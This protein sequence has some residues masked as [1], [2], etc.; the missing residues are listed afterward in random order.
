VFCKGT[1]APEEILGYIYI[2]VRESMKILFLLLSFSFLV[3]ALQGNGG[4]VYDPTTLTFVE[5]AKKIDELPPSGPRQHT[6]LWDT[7][8][9]VHL[10]YSPNGRYSNLAAMLVD[11]GFTIVMNGQ[12]VHNIDLSPYDIIVINI[13][14]S[15]N[16]AYTGAE[17][18]ALLSWYDNGHQQVIHTS[19]ANWCD[20]SYMHLADDSVFSCN[21]FKHLS[22]P[23]G[24]AIMSENTACPNANVAPV[25]Q[26][27]NMN[28]G[29][30]YLSPSDLYFSNFAA[31]PIYNSVS[32]VYYRAA[33]ELSAS[34]PA[35]EI[36]WTSTN[37]GTVAEMN[38]AIAIECAEF[39]ASRLPDAIRLRW[40]TTCEIGN[41]AWRIEAKEEGDDWSLLALVPSKG[42]SPN[43]SVYDYDD[44]DAHFTMYRYY[45]LGSVNSQ[46][47]VEWLSTV[48][49]DPET[50]GCNVNCTR[51]WNTPNPFRKC[52]TLQFYLC[53]PCHAF[54]GIYSASGRLV[55]V[56]VDEE[57]AA[58][59]HSLEYIP[60]EL[61]GG[62]YWCCL[63]TPRINRTRKLLFLE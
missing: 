45:R 58:G 48:R 38:E 47:K 34:A 55:E 54:L 4:T 40:R 35:Q 59:H 29:I 23:G 36:G 51:I 25:V 42:N 60:R 30:S 8:H 22:T 61:P 2:K 21:V 53:R 63:K 14:S 27:F 1:D 49:A 20:N 6:I 12:G 16:S 37:Q 11:S 10:L 52:T 15:W 31:H 26:A 3:T 17:V 13:A 41:A 9:G 62:V 43:G 7:T 56:L 19:D 24:I 50:R 18:N 44:H 28:C 57:R 46:G 33:G 5:S 39:A 32:Q